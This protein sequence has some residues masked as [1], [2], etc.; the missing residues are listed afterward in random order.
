[1][2]QAQ[3][4]KQAASGGGAARGGPKKADVRQLLKQTEIWNI[5]ITVCLLPLSRSATFRTPVAR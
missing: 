3:K 5:T 2:M 1:M 4:E